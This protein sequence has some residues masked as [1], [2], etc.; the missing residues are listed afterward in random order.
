MPEASYIGHM[1]RVGRPEITI[2]WQLSALPVAAV[3]VLG[4]AS[5]ATARSADNDLPRDA[6]IRR[7]AVEDQQIR[8]RRS[9]EADQN[10][11]LLLRD[12]DRR[13][14]GEAPTRLEVPV[15]RGNCQTQIYGSNFLKRC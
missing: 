6:Q 1:S 13:S 8:S 5:G 14:I 9:R 7:D 2:S 10:R 4:L 12:L 3:V 15:M 11:Q